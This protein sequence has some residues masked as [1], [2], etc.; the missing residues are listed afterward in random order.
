MDIKRATI[1]SRKVRQVPTH[2]GLSKV[3]TCTAVML[4]VK[5]HTIPQSNKLKRKKKLIAIVVLAAALET[6]VMHT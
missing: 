2:I 6:G 4:K 5:W 3:T 1:W